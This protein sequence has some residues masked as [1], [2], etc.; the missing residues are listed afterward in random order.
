[1]PVIGLVNSGPPEAAGYRAAAFRQGLN[2]MARLSA[3]RYYRIPL[4]WTV[5]P[6][7]RMKAGREH[8]VPLA[9]R[10]QDCE[11]DA[12]SRVRHGWKG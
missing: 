7:A 4:G 5:P 1:M 12:R 8:R 2:E 3:E 11:A 6:A 9:T 10:A